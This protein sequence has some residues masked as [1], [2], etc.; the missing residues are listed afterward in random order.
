MTQRQLRALKKKYL[1]EGYKMYLKEMAFSSK[2]NKDDYYAGLENEYNKDLEKY[3]TDY[4]TEREKFLRRIEYERKNKQQDRQK[5]YNDDRLMSN[6]LEQIAE[7]LPVEVDDIKTG[8]SNFS[9]ELIV[10]D[11]NC[12]ITRIL[13]KAVGYPEDRFAEIGF[14]FVGYKEHILKSATNYT[15]KPMYKALAALVNKYDSYSYDAKLKRVGIEE[16]IPMMSNAL[17][18]IMRVYAEINQNDPSV[19]VN[20]SGGNLT[21]EELKASLIDGK[22]ST[23]REDIFYYLGNR[24]TNEFLADL[25]KLIND[26]F[27]GNATKALLNSDKW[28]TA[29]EEAVYEEGGGDYQDG[30]EMIEREHRVEEF[31]YYDS[32]YVFVVKAALKR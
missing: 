29:D 19:N 16:T 15:V 1:R 20:Y 14:K 10:N 26:K 18:E 3:E 12:P 30:V 28:V 5:Q 7:A 27:G 17:T 8:F 24:G 6:M 25:T 32:T 13:I 21:P 23:W 4:N 11:E 2:F 22:H 31:G 9:G